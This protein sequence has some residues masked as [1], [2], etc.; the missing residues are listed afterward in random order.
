MKIYS[1][2]YVGNSSNYPYICVN[3]KEFIDVTNNYIVW[4][5]INWMSWMKKS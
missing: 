5:I 2:N 1:L 3:L 4:H